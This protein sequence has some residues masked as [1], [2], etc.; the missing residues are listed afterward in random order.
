MHYK[1][2]F[3]GW[4]RHENVGLRNEPLLCQSPEGRPGSREEKETSE[5]R[6]NKCDCSRLTWL[7]PCTYD[8]LRGAD[9][10]GQLAALHGAQ[11]QVLIEEVSIQNVPH[12]ILQRSSVAVQHSGHKI[13]ICWWIIHLRHP[14]VSMSTCTHR[15]TLTK[16][17]SV[18]CEQWWHQSAHLEKLLPVCLH[19]VLLAHQ[20]T[21]Y[22]Y[23]T[24]KICFLGDRK[25]IQRVN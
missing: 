20:C 24:I 12:G 2:A 13:H 1:T 22:K 18:V 17:L 14:N 5:P 9:L 15:I 7:S 23:S 8:V 16:A 21:C 25:C 6:G 19:H 4:W 3:G 10:L 11:V